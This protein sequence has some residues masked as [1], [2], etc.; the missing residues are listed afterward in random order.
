MSPSKYAS[1]AG[2]HKSSS[3][4]STTLSDAGSTASQSPDFYFTHLN[5]QS[6]NAV[7]QFS[8]R[9]ERSDSSSSSRSMRQVIRVE[10]V[11]KKEVKK[12]EK[13]SP[14]NS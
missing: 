5:V 3:N 14:K 9:S 8:L 11:P 2:Y 6:P 13:S 1:P 12:K 4:G 10:M 7:E